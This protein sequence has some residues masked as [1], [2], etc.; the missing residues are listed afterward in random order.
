MKKILSLMGTIGLSSSSILLTTQVVSCNATWSLEYKSI[1]KKD[2]QS[3]AENEYFDITSKIDLS[4]KIKR[5]LFSLDINSQIKRNNA[6]LR[7]ITDESLELFAIARAYFDSM[8]VI[9]DEGNNNN[10]YYYYVLQDK[11]IY[12]NASKIMNYESEKSFLDF[13]GD[14]I[15]KPEFQSNAAR[16]AVLKNNLKFTQAYYEVITSDYSKQTSQ[17]KAY[18][19]SIHE[20]NKYIEDGFFVP[21][22]KFI[23]MEKVISAGNSLTKLK[24]DKNIIEY[25]NVG[26]KGENTLDKYIGYWYDSKNKN[27]S[28]ILTYNWNCEHTYESNLDL[29]YMKLSNEQKKEYLN[30]WRSCEDYKGKPANQLSEEEALKIDDNLIKVMS[31]GI[32]KNDSK[33]NNAIVEKDF[34]L[35][36]KVQIAPRVHFNALEGILNN[37]EVQKFFKYGFQEVDKGGI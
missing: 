32:N 35:E 3:I 30:S 4:N 26:Q 27:T 24:F 16:F 25:L 10:D 31:L 7:E 15:I 9:D 1:L 6:L 36:E 17:N 29:D 5:N 23:V 18:I 34:G 13:F 19:E 12:G 22:L 28:G 21:L 11:E 14:E 37:E 33:I 2:A 20:M 8:V